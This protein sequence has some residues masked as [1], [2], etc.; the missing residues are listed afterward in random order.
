MKPIYVVNSGLY[1]AAGDSAEAIWHSLAGAPGEAQA[2]DFSSSL[3]CET[4]EEWNIDRAFCVNDP[5]LKELAIDRKT[6]RTMEKQ[7]R[8][9]LFAASLAMNCNAASSLSILQSYDAERIGLFLG[10]PMV[11]DP[12][13]P[14]SALERFHE[15]NGREGMEEICLQETLPFTG[16]AQLNSNLCSHVAATWNFRGAMGAFSASC[17][18]G[19]QAIIEAA[20]AI[21]EDD[22]SAVLA[23]GVSQKINPFLLLQFEHLGWVGPQAKMP[24]EGAAFLVLAKDKPAGTGIFISGV[25][26]GF[27]RNGL[28]A[29]DDKRYVI[30]QALNVAGL[31]P[32]QIGWAI[33]ALDDAAEVAARQ[34]LM[35]HLENASFDLGAALGFMGPAAPVC[36]MGLALHG[37]QLGELLATSNVGTVISHADAALAHVM[38]TAAGTEGQYVVVILSREAA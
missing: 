14:W 2:E 3:P 5:A 20:Y 1:C 24:G 11:E 35:P 7:A 25:A 22:A 32:Q 23:G 38:I 37:L 33:S 19:L 9:G 27:A 8:M 21:S 16:L 4:V 17:D 34:S 15:S 10:L 6:L 31:V 30:S 29:A 28:F 12:A 18:A 26:R 36:A 13:P